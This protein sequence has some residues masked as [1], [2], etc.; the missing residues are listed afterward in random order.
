M[1][2]DSNCLFAR[3]VATN[4]TSSEE[5]EK[6]V[7]LEKNIIKCKA[8]LHDIDQTLPQKNGTYLKVCIHVGWTPIR[9][10]RGFAFVGRSFRYEL[11]S[12]NRWK[13]VD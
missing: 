6:I 11:I 9:H 7:D 10:L 2:F 3:Y 13:R 4:V 5:K 1:S 12:G 8:Q